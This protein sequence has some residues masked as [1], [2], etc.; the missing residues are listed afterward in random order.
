MDK[1]KPILANGWVI[2]NFKVRKGNDNNF[3]SIVPEECIKAL[4]GI[5]NTE[6]AIAKAGG[7]NIDD[8]HIRYGSAKIWGNDY[9]NV[10]VAE[11]N[12]HD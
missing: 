12:C 1:Y 3:N 4:G 11:K 10:F 9:K 7:W 6:R 5:E 2:N 8:I